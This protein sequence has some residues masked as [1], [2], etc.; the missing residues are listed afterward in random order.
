MNVDSS[1][2]GQL[3]SKGNFSVFNYP[4]KTNPE[5]VN[6]CP[7]LLGQKFILRFGGEL[8]KPKSPFEVNWPLPISWISSGLMKRIREKYSNFGW[9]FRKVDTVCFGAS[10]H[11]WSFVVQHL[12]FSTHKSRKFAFFIAIYFANNMT[13]LH[14]LSAFK[15]SL[16]L[17]LS[18]K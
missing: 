1:P 13:V 4:K 8:K 2:K 10:G 17:Y 15:T 3:I 14:K 5:N 11:S 6:F 12:T 18:E 16:C 9:Y 7:S